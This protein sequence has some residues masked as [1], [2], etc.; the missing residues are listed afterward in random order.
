MAWRKDMNK[1]MKSL[2]LALALALVL[3]LLAGCQPAPQIETSSE[4]ESTMEVAQVTP[5]STPQPSTGL[6]AGKST[7]V[8]QVF[9]TRTNAPMVNMGVR[10]AE[11]HRQGEE[12]AFLLDTAFS[13]GD[14]TDEEGYF[15]F[16]NIEPGEYVVV[17][18][19]VEVY[20]G[21]VIIPDSTGRPQV[22]DF[23]S[24]EVTDIGTLRVG[25]DPQP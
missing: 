3:I 18:G 24:D 1:M 23:P 15:S 6:E 16:D 2:T 5:P 11:V 25:L 14:F 22:Y 10:L 13:P 4:P 20:E 21:Y 9:S 12:G 8:G 7:V 19:N 17:V